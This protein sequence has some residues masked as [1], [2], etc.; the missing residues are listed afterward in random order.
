MAESTAALQEAAKLQEQVAETQG[1]VAERARAEAALQGQLED[2][3][4]AAAQ[5]VK[6]ERS[7]VAAAE[8]A[9]AETAAEL[10]DR[11]RLNEA[12][13]VRPPYLDVLFHFTHWRV[14]VPLRRAAHTGPVGVVHARYH[15]KA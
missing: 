9:G 1:E 15:V 8:R 5:A 11:Q 13:Q 12:L 3:R 7:R 14:A 6:A 10:A 2:E 4:R